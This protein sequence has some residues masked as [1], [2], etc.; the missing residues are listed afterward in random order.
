MLY[1][2]HRQ[3]ACQRWCSFSIQRCLF[4]R[5]HPA[6][7][8]FVLW[9][10]SYLWHIPSALENSEVYKMFLTPWPQY[11]AEIHASLP[12]Y[13][14]WIYHIRTKIAKNLHIKYRDISGKHLKT[15]ENMMQFNRAILITSKSIQLLQ[16]SPKL[17]PP[18]LPL[19]SFLNSLFIASIWGPLSHTCIWTWDLPSS[20]LVL[21]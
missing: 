10:F 16:S 14:T 6:I 20:I 8:T 13:P 2:S 4:S 17:H 21:V 9:C 1:N 19:I 18:A 11:V 7:F 12:K 15:K 5:G 3:Y